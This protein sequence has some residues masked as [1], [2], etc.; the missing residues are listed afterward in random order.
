MV[1]SRRG[2]SLASEAGQGLRVLG[3]FVRQEL[4]SHKAA[5]FSVLG[6]VHHTHPTTAELLDDAVVRDG[7]ADHY[8]PN[9]E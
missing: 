1:Q 7:L 8:S 6:L 3:N 9:I 5:E 4:Q 2:L